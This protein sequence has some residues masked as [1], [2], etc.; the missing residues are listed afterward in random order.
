MKRFSKHKS[1]LNICNGL[2]GLIIACLFIG[3][4]IRQ[5]NRPKN[6]SFKADGLIKVAI[7]ENSTS[8]SRT[9][10][11]EK[12]LD[13]FGYNYVILG[14]G[15]QWNGWYGRMQ[16]CMAYLNGLDDE[17]YILFSDGRDV[18][19]GEDAQSFSEKAIKLYNKNGGK[20]IFNG[21]TLCC[22]AGKEFKGTKEEKEIY[23]EEIRKFFE[24]IQP[25]PAPP[26]YT[27][28]YGLAFGKVRDF[29]E[30]FYIM[31]LKP[32]EDDQG[33]LIQKIMNGEFNNYILDYDNT[34]FGIMY[35]K[36]PEWDEN[37]K[38]F[39][40]PTTKSFPGFLHFPGKSADYNN[41]VEVLLKE[42][43]KETPIL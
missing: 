7:Y 20:I 12:L 29:K 8:G 19:V 16:T 1:F 13:H 22:V 41:C 28:N 17:Q 23:F 5:L 33:V 30:M 26:L 6:E 36:K 37:K 34:L 2:A 38:Q 3:L 42:Y 11:L 24:G 35:D 43:L 9:S 39:S 14:K 4:F 18:L 25:H 40:N 31:D 27:L 15:D 32:E 10:N 21:E